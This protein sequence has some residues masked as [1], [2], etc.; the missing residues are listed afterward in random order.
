M[1]VIFVLFYLIFNFS[2]STILLSSSIFCFF[3]LQINYAHITKN[4]MKSTMGTNNNEA[5]LLLI[6]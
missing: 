5:I 2:P 3:L 4:I 1:G 6:K